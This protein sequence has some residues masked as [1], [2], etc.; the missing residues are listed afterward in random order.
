MTLQLFSSAC[1]PRIVNINNGTNKR[2]YKE[3]VLSQELDWEF[4]GMFLVS[5]LCDLGPGS[6][7]FAWFLKLLYLHTCVHHAKSKYRCNYVRAFGC[8][9]CGLTDWLVSWLEE[10]TWQ[11]HSSRAAAMSLIKCFSLHHFPLPS[12]KS[13][14]WTCQSSVY[15]QQ[16]A[17]VAILVVS[18]DY[19]RSRRGC[20]R[21]VL[22]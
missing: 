19:S 20:P 13:S 22:D 5:V 16:R 15:Q 18:N 8:V 10:L 2:T 11:Q 7:T 21:P 17:I 1:Q 14:V 4:S 3:R 6:C 12:E 9:D